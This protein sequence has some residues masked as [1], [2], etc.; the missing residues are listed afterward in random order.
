MQTH[1][2]APIDPSKP[3]FNTIKKANGIHNVI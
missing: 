3:N 1:T 2:I